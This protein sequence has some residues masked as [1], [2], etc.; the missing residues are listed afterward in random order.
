[1]FFR[2]VDRNN[3]TTERMA[4]SE[5][6]GV[7]AEPGANFPSMSHNAMLAHSIRGR[8][9][10]TSE[11]P[12]YCVSCHMTDEGL[13]NFGTEYDD[14][15]TALQNGD[16]ASLDW[17]LITQHI[18]Q[19]PGN[20][21]NS[22]LFVQQVAGFGSGLFLFDQQ[23][24]PVNPIDDHNDHNDHNDRAGTDNVPPSTVYDPNLV[25]YNLDL[26]VLE[27]GVST[28]SSNH[29]SMPPG[30]GTVLRLGATD[31]EM[32]GPPGSAS[33]TL[34]ADPNAGL[35]LDSWL[36]ADGAKLGD[37]DTYLD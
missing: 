29:A 21:L 5:R 11:G 33:L 3:T 28:A 18:G 23:G 17:N 13:A 25:V 37:A 14:F 31:V 10:S 16:W 22:P 12:R 19:N 36:D 26:L 27:N 4:F 15:R 24:R 34:L 8:V 2:W 32:A 9:T 1:M 7:G 6:K 35:V 20:Q 30:T